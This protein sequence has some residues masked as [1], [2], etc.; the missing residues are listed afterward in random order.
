[1]NISKRNEF[2]QSVENKAK[3]L[4]GDGWKLWAKPDQPLDVRTSASVLYGLRKMLVSWGYSKA[5]VKVDADTSTLKVAGQPIVKVV[6]NDFA[7]TLEWE[8]GE[9]E[10]WG[11]LQSSGEL[12]AVKQAAQTKLTE[13]KDRSTFK[14][15]GK[16]P[17]RG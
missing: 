4:A 7:L 13:A 3:R 16:R 11:S 10:S 12:A 15:K 14:G 6:V 9:W 17:G 8:D 2:V 1:V 5:C